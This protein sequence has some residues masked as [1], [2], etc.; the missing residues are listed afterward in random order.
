MSEKHTFK[1]SIMVVWWAILV[2]IGIQL[3]IQGLSELDKAKTWVD[4]FKSLFWL[5][6]GTTCIQDGLNR[7]K[8]YF[9][10]DVSK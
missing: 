10:G 2:V 1:I 5:A 7:L 9:S 3:A 6:V 4:V 8:K